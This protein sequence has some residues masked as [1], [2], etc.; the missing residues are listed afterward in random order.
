MKKYLILLFLIIFLILS[1]GCAAGQPGAQIVATT[2]PVCQFANRLCQG[3][4]LSAVQLITGNISCLHDYTLQVSQM[5]SAESAEVIV[6]SGAGLEDFMGDVLAGSG[7]VI[8]CSVGVS[9][10]ESTDGHDG[11]HGHE[12]EYDPHIWLSPASAKIMAQNICDGLCAE[13]PDEASLLRDNLSSLLSDLDALQAYG[14]SALS[15]LS[16]R[17]L[18]TFHDGFS[19]FAE[20]FGLSILAAVEEESGSEP[21]AQDLEQLI[22]LVEQHHLPAIFTEANGSTAAAGIIAQET[23]VRVYTLDMA[24]SSGD[25]FTAM[26]HNIDTIKEA[27]G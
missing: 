11:A 15:D 3:T 21:S 18:V 19:Y 16:C 1:C 27:L 25:Y 7:A 6:L 17:E 10:L 14:S 24:M 22:R 26:Y 9:L 23:G 5:R 20:A 4:G 13:Y 8:D 12:T 2:L